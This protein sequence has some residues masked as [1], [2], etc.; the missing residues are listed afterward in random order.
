M[1]HLKNKKQTEFLARVFQFAK[2]FLY[3]AASGLVFMWPSLW[4]RYPLVF[5]DTGAYV[6]SSFDFVFRPDRP[7]GY[8]LFIRL[9]S[10]HWTLWL[11]VF[12]Q[13]F[14]VS[15]LLWRL[16][17]IF[18]HKYSHYFHFGIIVF[19]SIFS[20]L[21]WMVSQ[22]M[23][24]LFP[25]LILM[26][27]FIFL[28]AEI[29]LFERCFLLFLMFMFLISHNVNFLFSLG[30]IALISLCLFFKKG[31]FSHLKEKKKYFQRIMVL[32]SVTLLT[33]IFFLASNFH[34]GFGLTLSP[35]SYI[36]LMTRVNESG[37]LD[38]FLAQNCAQTGYFLCSFQGHFPQNDQFIW[39]PDSP[40]A[41]KGPG[42]KGWFDSKP[43]FEAILHQIFSN[44]KYVEAFAGDS[45]YRS[46]KLLLMFGMDNFYPYDS[47]TSVYKTIRDYLP[48]EFSQYL[49]SRQYA[50]EFVS[51]DQYALIFIGT[52]FISW[53]G[54]GLM[55]F[56]KKGESPE[57]FFLFL[58]FAL[59][60]G[61]AVVMATLSGVY[62]RYQE[63]IVWLLPLSL[64]IFFIRIFLKEKTWAK[65]EF[66]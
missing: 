50:G 39:S 1:K 40:L 53:L 51:V 38:D 29:G 47:T 9:F 52:G 66:F 17:K 2:T 49:Q 35:I 36:F 28:F 55:L 4:N 5:S 24:D 37:I 32:T 22:V 3:L 12:A 25:G 54:L 44:P 64:A 59:L 21:P 18:I 27:I 11:V 60:I 58:V 42:W 7:I 26:I 57:K 23:P 10:L 34:G 16:L 48:N 41:L 46:L 33:P 65:A 14:I 8:S 56:M 63:R 31:I 30:L 43:E 20:S 45:A 15:Y 19:L 13:A 6:E 61:N 62:G